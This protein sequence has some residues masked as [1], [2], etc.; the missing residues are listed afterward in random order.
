MKMIKN[1]NI[2]SKFILNVNLKLL[3]FFYYPSFFAFE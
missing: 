2:I 1:E 3:F